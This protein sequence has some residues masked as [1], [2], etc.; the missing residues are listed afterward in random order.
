[1]CHSSNLSRPFPDREEAPNLPIPL[2]P[3]PRPASRIR[4]SVSRSRS[5]HETRAKTWLP[6]EIEARATCPL[7]ARCLKR[8]NDRERER[9]RERDPAFSSRSRALIIHGDI[10][11]ERGRDRGRVRNGANVAIRPEV[12]LGTAAF[13][14]RK[15][16]VKLKC[17][18]LLPMII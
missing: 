6:N 7:L 17:R 8:A 12:S 18:E 2:S 16:S 14:S 13:T 4:A 1:M 10:W 11:D 9:E 5:R 15:V 3:S